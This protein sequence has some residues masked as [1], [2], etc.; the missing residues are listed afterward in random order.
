MGGQWE[1]ERGGDQAMIMR[2][3]MNGACDGRGEVISNAAQE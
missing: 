1:G 3:G 2:G